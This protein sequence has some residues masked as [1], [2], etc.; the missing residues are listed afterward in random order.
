MLKNYDELSPIAIDCLQEIGNIGSG[1]AASS[2]SAMLSK[3]VAMH[4]PKIHVMDYQAVIDEMGGPEKIITAI[5]VTFKGDIK[6]MMMF[7]LE[8]AFAQIVVNTFMGKENIDVIQMDEADSSAVKEMGNIMAGAYLSA[9]AAMAEFTVHM[10]PPSM[11][12]D[13]MGA[14]MSAP[15]T[16]LDDVGDKVLFIDDGFKIDNVNIDA[17]IILIPEMESLDILTKKLGV[18]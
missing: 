18:N 2:L 15:M 5:L 11:T 9:L 7:L 4:V 16:T 1:N 13:M 3:P 14:L 12:V 6:G 10:D 8:N 17:N